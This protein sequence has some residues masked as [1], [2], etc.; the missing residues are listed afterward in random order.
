MKNEAWTPM[1]YAHFSAVREYDN[2]KLFSKENGLD[3][4]DMESRTEFT[5][6]AR[7]N[8]KRKS[9]DYKGKGKEIE[10]LDDDDDDVSAVD[11]DYCNLV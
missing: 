6:E 3:I 2:H 9:Y 1:H 10:E 7:K 11:D 4:D 5:E 8:K